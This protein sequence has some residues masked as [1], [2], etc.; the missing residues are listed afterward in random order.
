MT[1][2][3]TCLAAYDDQMRGAPPTPPAGVTYEK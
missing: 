2:T 1:D 3:Q